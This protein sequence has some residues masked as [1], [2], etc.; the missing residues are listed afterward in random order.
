MS[1]ANLVLS[2][3]PM[4]ALFFLV[5]LAGNWIEELAR[6]YARRELKLEEEE[7]K[8]R[9]ARSEVTEYRRKLEEK[10]EAAAERER[11]LAGL[12]SRM[13]EAMTQE[14]RL[15]DPRQ[16]IVYEIGVP[17]ANM[18]GLYAKAIGPANV[19]PFDGRASAASGVHGRRVARFILWG[20][21]MPHL[22]R[23]LGTFVGPQGQVV[24]KR[25]FSG[26][27]KLTEL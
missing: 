4:F 18:V 27:I 10:Q 9:Q 1:L 2:L 7:E 11:T 26:K 16:T 8:L 19:S 22:E 21:D 3:L 23:S 17:Q 6:E 25:P 24:V 20:R 14:I 13:G 5:G 12:T 15:T